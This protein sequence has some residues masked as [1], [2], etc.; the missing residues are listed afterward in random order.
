M[1][2]SDNPF[3]ILEVS[4]TDNRREIA[5]RGEEMALLLD[6]NKCAEAR[7]TLT[8][9][10]RRIEAELHWFLDCDGEEIAEIEGFIAQVLGGHSTADYPVSLSSSLTQFN[11]QMACL[12]AD[13]FSDPAM[14]I[15]CIL[16]L[17]QLYETIDEEETFSLINRLRAHAGFPEV[18]KISLVEEALQALRTELRQALS[19]KLQALPNDTYASIVTSLAESFSGIGS[20]RYKGQAVL[21]DVISE[22]QL[23]INDQLKKKSQQ[24]TKMAEHI[25][26]SADKIDVERVLADLFSLLSAWDKL[27]QPLQLGA[28]AT[29]SAHT[30]STDMLNALRK[31]STTLHNNHNL[32][33][34]ALRITSKA[35][36][37]FKEF[38]EHREKL[39][40]DREILAKILKN[41]KQE[42]VLA[43]ILAEIDEIH[44]LVEK[45]KLWFPS[46]RSS[47]IELVIAKVL[48]L[49]EHIRRDVSDADLAK[50]MR[51]NLAL[52][53]RAMG[54]ELFNAFTDTDNSLRVLTFARTTFSDLTDI[55]MRLDNDLSDLNKQIALKQAAEEKQKQLER[56]RKLASLKRSLIFPAF[57]FTIIFLA[58]CDQPWE[59]TK[60]TQRPSVSTPKP[61]AT[62]SPL[63]R[64]ANSTVFYCSTTERPS[65]FTVTN[66]SSSNYYIKFVTAGTDTKVITFFVRA[67]CTATIDM[68]VGFL[69]LRYA[70][71]SDWYG[72]QKLFGTNTRYAKDEEY[73]DFYNYNWEISFSSTSSTGENV[74]VEHISADEF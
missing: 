4:P 40:E 69:E 36:D 58:T 52:S 73:Y 42:K 15:N 64:P 57:L 60:P 50:T 70:C 74:N 10:H 61:V 71:G 65:Q 31:L 6:M 44:S 56:S 7:T 32:T 41:K 68:P 3:K 59:T 49:I 11:V 21:D 13:S 62:Q 63:P 51:T 27:A 19:Q 33:E 26:R 12:P 24:I 5:R 39:E 18:A 20:S 35:L 46:E 28:V 72:E 54:I 14:A 67:H 43:P 22:Y 30:D 1:Q 34:A 45:A 48:A 37:V 29:G 8:N 25:A 16:R 2:Y 55:R 9:P 38:P 47:K 23:F 53:L 66:S 17:S